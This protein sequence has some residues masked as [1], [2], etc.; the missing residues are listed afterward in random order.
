MVRKV[1]RFFG[2]WP[3]E[4]EEL[5]VYQQNLA[6]LCVLDHDAAFMSIAE[7]SGAFPTFNVSEVA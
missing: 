6:L 3:H 2:K 4:F 1:A 5:D 7:K